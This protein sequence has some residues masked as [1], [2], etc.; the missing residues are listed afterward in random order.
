MERPDVTCHRNRCLQSSSRRQSFP[1]LP[2]SSTF[3]FCL[4]PFF[5]VLF[6][7]PSVLPLQQLQ[8]H[9]PLP[10]L[11]TLQQP[12]ATQPSFYSVLLFPFPC[13]P[14]LFPPRP[15]LTT[16]G[17]RTFPARVAATATAAG[18]GNTV[19]PPFRFPFSFFLSSQSSSLGPA[20]PFLLFPFAFLLS[21]HPSRNVCSVSR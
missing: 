16:A 6:A 7:Q 1:M 14:A 4:S 19:F 10:P 17:K 9:A 20:F 12:P 8:Q 2:P 21:P 11:P 5:S 13:L 3:P 15:S 18:T